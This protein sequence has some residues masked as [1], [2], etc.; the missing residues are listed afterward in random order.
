MVTAV[1]AAYG[2]RPTPRDRKPLCPEQRTRQQL[3]CARQSG[4]RWRRQR[5]KA[6]LSARTVARSDGRLAR[7]R[8]EHRASQSH[9]SPALRRLGG[10]CTLRL[11]KTS[12]AAFLAG[13]ASLAFAPTKPQTSYLGAKRGASRLLA[14]RV[15]SLLAMTSPSAAGVGAPFL[16]PGRRQAYLGSRRRAPCSSRP[17]PHP[18]PRP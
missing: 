14:R 18:I 13:S 12:P 6:R 8:N 2:V 10:A 9:A 17:K 1:A 5:R 15:A 3:E 7:A 4:G 16:A 11:W